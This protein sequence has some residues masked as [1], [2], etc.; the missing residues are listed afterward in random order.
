MEVGYLRNQVGYVLL[1][2][3]GDDSV[4]YK[5]AE[6]DCGGKRIYSIL[7]RDDVRPIQK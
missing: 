5:T 2:Q 3:V 1:T 6:D 4:F 7:S